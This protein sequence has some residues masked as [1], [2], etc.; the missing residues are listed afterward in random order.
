MTEYKIDG[1]R[2]D[3]VP[4]VPKWFW[5]KY[6]SAAGVYTVGEVFDGDMG[7]VSGYL[8]SMDAVLNYPFFF[9]ARDIIFNTKDMYELRTYY[10]DWA[11][12]I[13]GEKLNYL[14]NF[15]DNHD[16]ARIMSW[17]GDW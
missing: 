9:R 3:T 13:D 6:R 4:E 2:I 17:S 10:I 14:C 16:N 15:A 1:L 8:G 12:H 11:K 7:Y 5:A